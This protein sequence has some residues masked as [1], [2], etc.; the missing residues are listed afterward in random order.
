MRAVI[1]ARYSSDKQRDASIEDQIEV[2][3]R[4]I[5]R[6]GWTPAGVYEDRAISGANRLRGGYQQLRTDVRTG[7][8]DIIVC[9]ALDRM[10]RNLSEVADLHDELGYLGIKLMTVATGEVTALHI[11]MLG[12]M[13]QMTLADLK[14]KTKRGQLGRALQG[15]IPGGL[16]FGYD[17]IEAGAKDGRG[18]RR[19]NE[20]EAA[21]VRRIFETYANGSSPR[22][23]ARMLNAEGA[24]GPDGRDWRDTTIRGQV[25]RGTG[26]LNNAL[27]VG[28]LEWNRCSY[29][30]NPRT[31]RRVARVNPKEQWEVVEVP[32]LRIIADDLWNRTKQRQRQARIEIGRNEAGN[33]LN[34][35]HRRQFLF[36][37][38]LEC[39]ICGGGYTIIGKDRYGCAT[40]RAKGTCL[41]N[42]T[43]RRQVI[44]ARVLD[45]LKHRLMAP[46]LFREFAKAFHDEINRAAT[47]RE[48][49]RS[50]LAHDLAAIERKIEGMFRAIEDGLYNPSMKERM[51]ALEERKRALT[52]EI[53]R[54]TGQP[55][56]HLHPNLSRIY[57]DKVARLAD[58]LNADDI[59]TEAAELIRGLIDKVVLTPV[60]ASM[61]A[62]LYG[63]LAGILVVCDEFKDE[64]PGTG[65]G[66]QLSVVAGAGFEP[67][68]FRL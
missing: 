49:R 59:K 67:A 38:L 35:V 65:P 36:S 29:V 44:E 1:Y 4:L 42:R 61:R 40:H 64:L 55:A 9:E 68:T 39:G 50:Q 17:V 15:K 58:A 22:A 12:T 52:D 43:V 8:F 19:I 62:E 2:C 46:E 53:G 57:A 26:I 31:G 5:T 11:G 6:E 60:E 37:G 7:S 32:D 3:R 28:R 25:D 16:A 10:G 45:G 14:E 21:I 27:Y 63:D 18:R 56:V 48:S 20:S 13:A 54:L 24:P 66:S 34:R 47:E 23:I 30:K 41:N 51:A 33:A